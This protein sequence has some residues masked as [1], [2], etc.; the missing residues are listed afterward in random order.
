MEEAGIEKAETFIAVTNNDET[1]ILS[2]LLAQQYGCDRVIPLVNKGAYSNLT[3]SLGLGAV[4]S[5]KAL[6]VSSIMKY[7]RRGRVKA[8]HNMPG[9]F[10]EILE[11]EASDSLP[12]INARLADIDFPE[13]VFVC[14]IERDDEIIIPN[15]DSVIKAEDR[16]I[17]LALRGQAQKVEQIF[18]APV[19]LF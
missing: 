14:A 16:V 15:K 19:D 6:T 17:I 10:A 12:I 9:N 11:I 1:N 18:S 3:S 4:L 2:S 7:V 5:P 8:V 13:G